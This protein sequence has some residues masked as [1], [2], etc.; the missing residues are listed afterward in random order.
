MVT[1][2]CLFEK[3]KELAARFETVLEDGEWL[4]V[5]RKAGGHRDRRLTPRGVMRLPWITPPAGW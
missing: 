5:R 2:D 3:G 1:T 4:V